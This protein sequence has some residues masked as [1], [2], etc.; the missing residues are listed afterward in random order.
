[1]SDLCGSTI[2][3][4]CSTYRRFSLDVVHLVFVGP[5]SSSS[6]LVC[7]NLSVSSQS[8]RARRNGVTLTKRTFSSHFCPTRGLSN[9]GHSVT[10]EERAADGP[11]GS[12]VESTSCARPRVLL[13]SS[14]T[15]RPLKCGKLLLSSRNSHGVDGRATVGSQSVSGTRTDS[16]VS[17]AGW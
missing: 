10:R 14:V 5:C 1:M 11:E 13:S 7:L 8:Q 6:S 17:T 2:K 3:C 15:N 12:V 16:S 4:G 9:K